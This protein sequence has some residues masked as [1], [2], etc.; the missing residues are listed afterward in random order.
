MERVL[1]DTSVLVRFFV[2]HAD[3]DQERADALLTAFIEGRIEFL[4]LDLSVY[5]CINVL[6]KQMYRAAAEVADTITDLYELGAPIVALDRTLAIE[7]ALV[8][9][10][11][12]LS[13]YDASFLAA[14]R[15]LGVTL[16]TGD[17]LL[18]EVGD[19]SAIYLSDLELV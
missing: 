19:A 13:G 16:V 3:E 8:A 5:E 12:E 1:L 15:S 2:D 7:A 18:A 17:R 14:A 11:T 9:G 4:L 6:A 10:G